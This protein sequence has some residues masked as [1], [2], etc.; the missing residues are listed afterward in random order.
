MPSGHCCHPSGP[1][2]F[3]I[4]FSLHLVYLH[5]LLRVLE[6]T[7]LASKFCSSSIPLK[8][9][10]DILSPAC[11]IDNY[12]PRHQLLSVQHHCLP[13]TSWPAGASLPAFYV[14]V[15][16]Y[17][18]IAGCLQCYY[19]PLPRPLHAMSLPACYVVHVR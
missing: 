19:L 9:L 11:F 17:M 15:P 14:I 1:L 4:H 2:F 18:Y 10:I 8:F 6:L 7:D 12:L 16:E 3:I 13:A 5:L